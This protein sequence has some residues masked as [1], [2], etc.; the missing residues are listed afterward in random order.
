MKRVLLLSR[1]GNIGGSQ[2][3]LLLLAH[4]LDT[5]RHQLVVVCKSDGAIVDMLR[6][7]GVETLVLPLGPWRKLT[8]NF[9]RSSDVR[10]LVELGKDR[11]IAI[12]H[13]SDL[14]MGNH[15]KKIADALGIPSVLHVRAPK[16]AKTLRKHACRNASA[17]IA[18]SNRVRRH[19]IDAGVDQSRIDVIYDAA[20]LESFTPAAACNVLKRDYPSS[21]GVLVGIAGRIK[22]SKRQF[23]FIQAAAR[24]TQNKPGAA[25]FFVIG[26][27]H[28]ADYKRRLCDL[29]RQSGL[30]NQLIFTGHRDDMP[31]VLSSLDVLVTLSG[32]SVMIESMACGTPVISA[33][34]TRANESTIV[35]HNETG[36]LLEPGCEHELHSDMADLIDDAETRVRLGAAARKHVEA[37]FDA[38]RLSQATQD[39]YDK[40]LKNCD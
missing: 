18:I 33:G 29:A 31:D 30:N 32:G 23:E 13:S 19:C 12:A 5:T 24:V 36:L 20:N 17:L 2:R 28:K 16:S 6:N 14:W 11:N 9:S 34:F 38:S 22:E 35:L 40:V 8:R 37:N 27:S 25:T 3:Q 4:G 15:L 26:D 10:R 1:G 7:I 21:G 39:V